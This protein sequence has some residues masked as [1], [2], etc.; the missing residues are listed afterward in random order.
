MKLP[1]HEDNS[2]N[3]YG[4]VRISCMVLISRQFDPRCDGM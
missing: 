4:D 2:V 3:Q 1:C